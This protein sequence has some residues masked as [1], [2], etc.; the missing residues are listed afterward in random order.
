M[1]R[2]TVSPD[3]LPELKN[4]S[5]ARIASDTDFAYLREE[6]DQFKKVMTEKSVS[7]NE[8]RRMKEKQEAEDRVK[9]RRKELLARPASKDKVYLVT[10][11]NMG[12]P[13]LTLAPPPKSV[14]K[15]A[16]PHSQNPIPTDDAAGNDATAPAID[17][18]LTESER[19]LQDILELSNKTAKT[20]VKSGQ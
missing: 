11:E 1:S 8:A 17:T 16:K 10:L 20:V 9:A 15:T 7:L 6:I 2:K 14:D 12:K 3:I 4:R 18:T 19:I 13:T 5:D